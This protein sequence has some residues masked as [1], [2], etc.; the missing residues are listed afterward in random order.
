MCNLYSITK[1]PQA[2]REFTQAMRDHVG[3]MPPLPGVFP[4]YFAPI[5]RSGEDSERELVMARWGMPSP[6]EVLKGSKRDP[7]PATWSKTKSIVSATG[8]M[9]IRRRYYDTGKIET[10]R[11]RMSGRGYA[12]EWDSE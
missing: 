6:L 5:V 3:N 7:G 11:Y 2:I 1:G 9:T 8:E 10:R 12:E 4:D